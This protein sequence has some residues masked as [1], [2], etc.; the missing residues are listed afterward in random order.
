M[1]FSVW[2][3]MSSTR[4]ATR[5]FMTTSNMPADMEHGMRAIVL[6]DDDRGLQSRVLVAPDI[7][8]K[9]GRGDLHE[10]S[11]PYPFYLK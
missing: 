6:G 8:L 7:L 1:A 10:P 11:P 9:L 2:S 3:S 5:P 4:R